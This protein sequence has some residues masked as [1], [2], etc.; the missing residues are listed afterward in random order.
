VG[1]ASSPREPEGGDVRPPDFAHI[2][3]AYGFAHRRVTSRGALGAA[4]SEF[5]KRRQVVILE[6]VASEFV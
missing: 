6:I 1:T 5:G 4:L 3:A 2:A